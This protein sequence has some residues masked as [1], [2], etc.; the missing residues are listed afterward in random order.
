[1]NRRNVKS[2]VSGAV[3][4]CRR[5]FQLE[6]ETRVVAAA[7]QYLGMT[8]MDDTPSAVSFP[9]ESSTDAVKKAFLNKVTTYVV[10]TFVVDHERNRNIKES[11]HKFELQSKEKPNPDGRYPCRFPGCS[12]T[13]VHNGKC[14]KEH[15]AGHNPPLVIDDND[16]TSTDVFFKSSKEDV[17]N[18]DKDRDDMLSYQKALLDYG[19]LVLNFFDGISE[20][21]GERVYCCWKYFLMYLKHHGAS[22]KYALEALYFIFQANALLSPRS[23]HRLKWNRFVKNKSGPG[24]NIPLDLQLEFYNRSVKEAVKKLGPNASVKSINR[25]CH[26]IGFTSD[27]MKGFDKNL[28]IFKRSGK[29]VRKSIAGDFQKIVND[30]L[31]NKAFYHTPGRVYRCFARMKTSI[32]DG[33]NMRKMYKWINS[34]KKYMILNRRAR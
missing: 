14:R 17:D 23:A 34:H 10:D 28:S 7:M 15:E 8:K 26:C 13:F 6:V 18:D 19:M 5:F 30:L 3:N 16:D 27:L 21:D 31:Q 20:G 24:G 22:D 2:D 32:L 9:S 33:F 25:I 29:H 11:V 1:M 4:A 12:R